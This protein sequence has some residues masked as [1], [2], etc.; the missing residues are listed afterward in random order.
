MWANNMK[1]KRYIKKANRKVARIIKEVSADYTKKHAELLQLKDAN[2]KYLPDPFVIAEYYKIKIVYKKM[3]S[4]EPSYLD[5]KKNTIFISDKYLDDKY[6]SKKFVAH[7]LGHYFMDSSSLA[8]LNN[9]ILNRSLPTE[10]MNEYGANVFAIILM[11]QIMGGEEWTECSPDVL[12]RKAYNRLL[13][14]QSIECRIHY[15]KF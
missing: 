2:I 8:A 10:K 6:R 5:R 7:E 14:N 3:E 9:D 12:N 4:E 15:S 1:H 11:P 13:E